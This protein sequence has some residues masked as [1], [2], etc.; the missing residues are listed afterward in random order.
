MTLRAAGG[1]TLNIGPKVPTRLTSEVAGTP[2]SYDK[3]GRILLGKLATF[4]HWLDAHGVPGYIG[5]VGWPHTTDNAAWQSLFGEFYNRC[6]AANLWVTQWST[7][8]NWSQGYD[9][10]AYSG[11]PVNTPRTSAAV[12]EAHPGNPTV[13]RGVNVS[14]GEFPQ[15][16]FSSASPGVF[17]TDY[18]Y[19]SAATY[20]YLG[21]RGLSLVRIPFHWERL[22]PTLGAAL[23]ATELGRLTAAVNA[24]GA[25]GLK[26][27]LDC[28]NYGAYILPGPT[29]VR[30]GS[31][32]LTVDHFADLWAR[33]AFAFASNPA[34]VAYGL[35]NEAQGLP[36]PGATYQTPTVRYGFDADI[37][38]WATTNGE[39]WSSQQGGSMR[40]TAPTSGVTAET[41]TSLRDRTSG[42][43]SFWVDIY[44]PVN[45]VGTWDVALQTRDASF[46][47]IRGEFIRLVK[48][49]TSRLRLD[50]TSGQ[51]AAIRALEIN[52]GGSGRNG[53]DF[54]YVT[55]VTQGTYAST[56]T[57]AG[58]WVIASQHAVDAI[59]VEDPTK[60][61]CV[62]PY[63][64]NGVDPWA[65]THPA[66]WISGSGIRY[67]YHL[68]G[69]Y[70]AAGHYDDS[71]AV[72]LAAVM[73][74]G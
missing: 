71:Y 2:L 37:T 48:G 11:V 59:R 53:T 69:D 36:E 34:V 68:Y 39:V 62:L 45:A 21:S 24:A 40:V 67:E 23:N 19:G 46:A 32:S 55:E 10:L 22:Q 73:A 1:R 43:L 12:L 49:Q 29:T 14:G 60:Q 13:L 64:I 42:G 8:D 35:M 26:V 65:V 33:L 74:L 15:A 28:H 58:Q 7:G 41:D 17:G 47:F 66:P 9:L 56:G 72:D 70:P 27:V 51:A 57:A 50:L 16:G 38:G 30:I 31:A 4:T 52:W 61:I 25:A 5:E 20:A 18:S 54:A 63:V 3:L 44:L 6:D